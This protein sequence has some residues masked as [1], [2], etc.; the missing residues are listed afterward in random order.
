MRLQRETTLA[1][2]YLSFNSKHSS[3]LN[4][5]EYRTTSSLLV[6]ELRSSPTLPAL[7]PTGMY[8]PTLSVFLSC[9]AVFRLATVVITNCTKLRIYSAIH[10]AYCG[11]VFAFRNLAK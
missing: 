9:S 4:D 6:F 2:P 3:T 10:I 8:L 5:Y 11:L 7:L 1:L